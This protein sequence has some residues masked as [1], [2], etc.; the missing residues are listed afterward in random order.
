MSNQNT[1]AR[2]ESLVSLAAYLVREISINKH[3]LANC[4]DKDERTNLE[5]LIAD[6]QANV[7]D[8]NNEITVLVE[9]V[10]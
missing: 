7:D 9:S 3:K 2:V 6:Q 8:L 10:Q 1:V 5:L 4:A